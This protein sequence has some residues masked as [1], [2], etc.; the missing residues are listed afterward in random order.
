MQADLQNYAQWVASALAEGTYLGI[1]EERDNRVVAGIGLTLLNWG[2]V[3]GSA[4]PY[5]GR[6][7]DAFTSSSWRGRGIGSSL[8][9]SIL[10]A[11]RARGVDAFCLASTSLSRRLYERAGFV[12]YKD[13]MRL[14]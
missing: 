13:E 4:S 5:R 12:E 2:P 6:I 1:L 9:R 8:L 7:V 3:R 10:E 11:G 14:R